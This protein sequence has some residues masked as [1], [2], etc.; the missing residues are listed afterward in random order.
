MI[1]D[2]FELLLRRPLVGCHA[3]HLF[4]FID[5]LLLE[6]V[7]AYVTFIFIALPQREVLNTAASL[8]RNLQKGKISLIYSNKILRALL[9]TPSHFVTA[10]QA[11]AFDKLLS[12]DPRSTISIT[13]TGT[14][15]LL[16]SKDHGYV[17]FAG[18]TMKLKILPVQL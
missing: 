18:V 6:V 17:L 11:E 4:H 5:R 3:T 13:K 14:S 15:D 7:A 2:S 1:V 10:E 12:R 8:L 16:A 9:T